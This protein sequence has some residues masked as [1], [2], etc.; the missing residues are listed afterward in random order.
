[1]SMITGKRLSLNFTNISKSYIKATAWVPRGFAARYPTK[2]DVDENE[3]ARI[4]K[5]AQISLDDA[6]DELE[7]AK[8]GED[9]E[10]ER[11][12]DSEAE[13]NGVEIKESNE[14]VTFRPI[15]LPNDSWKI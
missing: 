14:C 15:T 8:A 12:D 9:G 7:M 11:K 13:E 3:L 1:M 4:S 10:V 5:L 2:Y 6:K